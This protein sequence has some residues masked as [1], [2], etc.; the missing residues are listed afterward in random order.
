M[1]R[2]SLLPALRRPGWRRGVACLLLA[3]YVLFAVAGVGLVQCHEEDGTVAT[4]WRGADCCDFAS[5]PAHGAEPGDASNVSTP[6]ADD[7]GGCRDVSVARL[8]ESPR[9]LTRAEVPPLDAAVTL[10]ALAWSMRTP[11]LADAAPVLPRSMP[12]ADPPPLA[13]IRTVQLRL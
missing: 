8:I 12:P 6:D 2:Q 9:T 3:V 11:G 13:A 7:C 4:E 5:A 10:S 1:R